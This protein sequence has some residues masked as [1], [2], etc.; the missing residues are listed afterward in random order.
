MKKVFYITALL[1]MLVI[2][3]SCGQK[4]RDAGSGAG[5]PMQIPNVN[6]GEVPCF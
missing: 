6:C 2:S 3:T 5:N 4:L 1:S